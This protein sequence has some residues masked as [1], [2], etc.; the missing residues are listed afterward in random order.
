VLDAKEHAAAELGHMFDFGEDDDNEDDDNEDDEEDV[1]GGADDVEEEEVDDDDASGDDVVDDASGD[2]N[3]EAANESDV[4]DISR[5]KFSFDTTDEDFG[6]YGD[7][8]EEEVESG[9]DEEEGE[10]GEDEDE[11]GD[12][13]EGGGERGEGEGQHVRQESLVQ[14]VAKGR[15]VQK[16]L[17]IWDKERA[18]NITFPCFRVIN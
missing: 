10:E 9:E 16:Q 13:E 6:K 17:D 12:E 2:D 5:N 7:M 14:E 1:G 3:N 4:R 8:D 15:A 11:E 18:R